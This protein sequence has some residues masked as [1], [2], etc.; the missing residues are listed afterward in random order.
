MLSLVTRDCPECRG[1]RLFEQ[2]HGI[3]GSCPDTPDGECPEWACT[4]CGTA[5]L[6]GFPLPQAAPPRWQPQPERV[7]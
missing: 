4:E 5:L 7:A 1:D 3:G 6:A 2:P